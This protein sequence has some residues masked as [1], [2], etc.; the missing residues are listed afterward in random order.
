M[1]MTCSLVHSWAR[2]TEGPTSRRNLTMTGPRLLQRRLGISQSG[3]YV[4]RR[5]LIVRKRARVSP[6]A[7]GRPLPCIGRG[8]A[9]YGAGHE[10]ITGN[11]RGS[12]S[13]LLSVYS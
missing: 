2:T 5:Q 3:W 4:V 13:N 8:E 6:S 12:G 1:V 9:A 7:T 11:R 10:E